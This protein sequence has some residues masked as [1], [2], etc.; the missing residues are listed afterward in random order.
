M[1]EGVLEEY[2]EK[3]NNSQ[4]D[5]ESLLIKLEGEVRSHI[6]IENML[7]I[8]SENMQCEIEEM[9]KE[10]KKLKEKMNSDDK[11]EQIE[12]LHNEHNKSQKTN[13]VLISFTM[14]LL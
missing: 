14:N 10:N 7:K 8:E 1:S 3:K 11:E 13:Q 12:K 5:Y 4:E 2:K 6:G 9:E